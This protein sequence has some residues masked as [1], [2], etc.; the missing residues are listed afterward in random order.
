MPRKESSLIIN[1]TGDSSDF[2]KALRQASKEIEGLE[3][4]RSQVAKLSGAAIEATRKEP[5]KI[6]ITRNGGSDGTRTRDLRRDRPA[7]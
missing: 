3:N 5:I 7:L 6:Y 4:S 2:R 1:I